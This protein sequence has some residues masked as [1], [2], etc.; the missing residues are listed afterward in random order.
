MTAEIIS[1]CEYRAAR[2]AGVNA[3]DLPMKLACAGV[4][5]Q[6]YL[7]QVALEQMRAR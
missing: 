6:I 1:L 4:A 3:F 2:R 7:L 5:F